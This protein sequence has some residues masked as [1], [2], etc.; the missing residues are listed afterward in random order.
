[1]IDKEYGHVVSVAQRAAH[2]AA[3]LQNHLEVSRKQDNTL[4]TQADL[5]VS[6]YILKELNTLFPK[7]QAFTEE[8]QVGVDWSGRVWV[9]DPIDGT[10]AYARKQ[11][12]W[13]VSIGLIHNAEPVFGVVATPK[14]RTYAQHGKGAYTD[15]KPIST[16][17]VSD[18]TQATGYVTRTESNEYARLA[19][20]L[21]KADEH[22]YS[23]A[24]KYAL[25]AQGVADAYAHLRNRLLK[26]DTAGG[27]IIVTEAGGTITDTKGNPLDYA[28]PSM[29]WEHGVIA[30]NG[31]LH[32][33]LT[34]LS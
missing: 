21:R 25:V 33:Q 34:T 24:A 3:R 28:Q 12:G 11:D 9:V 16:S 32:K 7:D 26:W 17:T 14:S 20:H 27:H 18:L 15:G 8:D 2:L 10:T 13:S 1:M 22:P 31:L 29:R 23:A 30:S 6:K 4:L 19:A 5:A